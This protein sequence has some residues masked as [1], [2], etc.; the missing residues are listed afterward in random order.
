[1]QVLVWLLGSADDAV[2]SARLLHK[3]P[4]NAAVRTQKHLMNQP[5]VMLL[6]EPLCQCAPR[7]CRWTS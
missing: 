5:V 3:L 6:R 1:M 2:D 4:H 7:C